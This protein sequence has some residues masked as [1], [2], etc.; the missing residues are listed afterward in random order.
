[1]LLDT[2]IKRNSR[3]WTT[4]IRVLIIHSDMWEDLVHD[5]RF[6]ISECGCSSESWTGGGGG[7]N[8][9]QTI[10]H[11]KEIQCLSYKITTRMMKLEDEMTVM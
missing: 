1:M 9:R 3:Q 5:I 2:T 10:F 11:N 4:K 6:G 7:S 8:M